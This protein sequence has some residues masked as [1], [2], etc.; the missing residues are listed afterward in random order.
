M[1]PWKT[2]KALRLSQI[3]KLRKERYELALQEGDFAKASRAA[4]QYVRAASRANAA[5]LAAVEPYSDFL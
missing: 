2:P 1:Q 5:A 3:E 4:K